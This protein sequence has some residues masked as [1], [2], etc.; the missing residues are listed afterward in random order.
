MDKNDRGRSAELQIAYAEDLNQGLLKVSACAH[1]L[2]CPFFSRLSLLVGLV[3]PSTFFLDEK[4]RSERVVA[5]RTKGAKSA[6]V[7]VA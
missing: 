5:K 2:L 7:S 1:I 4:R 6:D 3:S